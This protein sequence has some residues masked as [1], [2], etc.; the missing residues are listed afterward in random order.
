VRD[1]ERERDWMLVR[2]RWHKHRELEKWWECRCGSSLV[3]KFRDG[4]VTECAADLSHSPDTHFITQTVAHEEK[5]KMMEYQGWYDQGKEN[6]MAFVKD[7]HTE[8][9]ALRGQPRV[10]RAGRIALGEK[11]QGGG[12]RS[13][14]YFRFVPF[15]ETD[16][17][18]AMMQQV[19]TVLEEYGID[20]EQPK[21]LP[22]YLPANAVEL[23][24]SSSYKL[25]G[26]EGR[27]RCV[28]DGQNINFKLGPQNKLEVS[29]D[30]VSAFTVNIDGTEF[31]KGEQIPCPGR[32]QEGRWSHCE[33]CGLKLSIDLQI[34]HLPYIWQLTTGDQAFYDQFFT[35]LAMCQDYVRQG[36][37][38]FLTEIP[39]LLRR[40]PGMKARP[41]ERQ[42][43]TYLKWQEMPTLS[44]E[45]H[46]I[47]TATVAA[48]R[49]AS[50]TPGGAL[51]ALPEGETGDQEP[52]EK[53]VGTGSPLDKLDWAEGVNKDP[54]DKEFWPEF[55]KHVIA[56][57]GY[58]DEKSINQ[59]LQEEFKTGKNTQSQPAGVLWSTL[60]RR[61]TP[62]PEG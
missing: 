7:R 1:Y 40:E 56:Q 2:G 46:P 41:E 34:A 35:V 4:W 10:R 38:R 22:A 5:A 3:L 37:A 47:W 43:E 14:P 57:M 48:S 51:K 23:F 28:G 8:D 12:A 27:P 33:K 9:G 39:L 31:K 44:I 19:Q 30:E 16:A 17:G 62:P 26:N 20:S 55:Y 32:A 60:Q 42:G 54:V 58:P 49:V 53:I 61:I 21:A 52:E 25:A 11:R 15:E 50:L 6:R 29:H 24:A 45:V 13:L 18:L 36:D 59:V